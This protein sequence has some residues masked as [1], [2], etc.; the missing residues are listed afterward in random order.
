MII[1]EKQVMELIS[2]A[3]H[4]LEILRLE[5]SYSDYHDTIVK[6]LDEINDQQSTEL[7][8]IK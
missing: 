1:S 8:E 3:H 5:D 6:L 4:H 2:I 7:K